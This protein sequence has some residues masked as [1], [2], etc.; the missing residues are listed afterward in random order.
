MVEVSS[1]IPQQVAGW[2]EPFP[3]V[4]YLVAVLECGMVVPQ[5]LLKMESSLAA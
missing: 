2:E 4:D 3:K 1:L 5:R